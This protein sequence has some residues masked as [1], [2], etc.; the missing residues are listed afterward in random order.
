MKFL[1]ANKIAPDGTPRSAASHLG[2][3]CLPMPHKKDTRLI[4]VKSSMKYS[5]NTW[6]LYIRTRT[7]QINYLTDLLNDL[8]YN[9]K[10]RH[11]LAKNNFIDVLSCGHKFD[12]AVLTYS[13]INSIIFASSS[14]DRTKPCIYLYTS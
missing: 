6:L 10:W 12:Q 13:S 4:W 9:I 11:K 1:Y 14:R 8:R 3:L 7:I 5:D 2:L